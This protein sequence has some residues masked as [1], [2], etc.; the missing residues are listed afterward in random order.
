MKIIR[1]DD[2]DDVNL[3]E[4][5]S[6]LLTCHKAYY[7]NTRR[8]YEKIQPITNYRRKYIREEM[9]MKNHVI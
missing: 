1:D 6:L 9:K 5:S 3:A 4:I 8:T 2:D 7:K